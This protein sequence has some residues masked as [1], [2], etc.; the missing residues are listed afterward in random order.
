MFMNNGTITFITNNVIS[1]LT[2]K[3]GQISNMRELKNHIENYIQKNY[4]KKKDQAN[5]VIVDIENIWKKSAPTSL[6]RQDSNNRETELSPIPEVSSYFTI[7]KSNHENK[8]I[9]VPMEIAEYNLSNFLDSYHLFKTFLEGETLEGISKNGK[10]FEQWKISFDDITS[11]AHAFGLPDKRYS[12]RMLFSYLAYLNRQGKYD[13]MRFFPTSKNNDVEKNKQEIESQIINFLSNEISTFSS[14]EEYQ[15]KVVTLLSSIENFLKENSD[16]LT[17]Q[18]AENMSNLAKFVMSTLKDFD[19][20]LDTSWI[21]QYTYIESEGF[22]HLCYSI[23]SKEK[24]KYIKDDLENSYDYNA[25]FSTLNGEKWEYFHHLSKELKDKIK[26]KKILERYDDFYEK[27]KGF[28]DEITSTSMKFKTWENEELKNSLFQN[29]EGLKEYMNSPENIAENIMDYEDLKTLCDELDKYH[30]FDYVS[31]KDASTYINNLIQY[32]ENIPYSLTPDQKKELKE[33]LKKYNDLLNGPIKNRSQDTIDDFIKNISSLEWLTSN[34]HQ[35]EDLIQ[36]YSKITELGTEEISLAMI[37][38]DIPQF[39]QNTKK[40]YEQMETTEEQ[41]NTI[42]G[43]LD[44]LEKLNNNTSEYHNYLERSFP[45]DL[46]AEMVAHHE[47]YFKKSED[48][49]SFIRQNSRAFPYSIQQKD[50]EKLKN[51]WDTQLEGYQHKTDKIDKKEKEEEEKQFLYKFLNDISENKS[52]EQTYRELFDDTKTRDFRKNV[53]K[54]INSFNSYLERKNVPDIVVF[55]MIP[56]IRKKIIERSQR[57]QNL[58]TKEQLDTTEDHLQEFDSF[59]KN[60]KN[61]M[62][63]LSKEIAK[64]DQKIN[65]KRLVDFSHGRAVREIAWL[66]VFAYC[67]QQKDFIDFLKLGNFKVR[68]KAK[69]DGKENPEFMEQTMIPNFAK[70]ATKS[71]MIPNFVTIFQRWDHL[72]ATCE[73]NKICIQLGDYNNTILVLDKLNTE[74]QRI[75]N[76]TIYTFNSLRLEGAPEGSI[77]LFVRK[78][79]NNSAEVKA[80][81]EYYDQIKQSIENQRLRSMQQ[82]DFAVHRIA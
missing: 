62:Q 34:I 45:N 33:Y 7:Q 2:S 35:A 25:L 81:E 32:I 16:F 9:S 63:S 74:E 17:Y 70:Q 73:G 4:N 36:L 75:D 23:I 71:Y 37:L 66:D 24:K 64:L 58:F 54:F 57:L 18:E 42:A 65:M 12:K 69:Y 76:N 39:I 82:Q 29:L 61:C 31:S 80:G 72:K 60:P 59:F 49:E 40:M 56:K 22:P 38:T 8:K 6:T 77:N 47:P 14:T 20:M 43:Y 13:K 26:T 67:L 21:R 3:Y 48:L 5:I 28:E 51:E 1:Y 11:N 30:I 27:L 55:Y 68:F 41:K 44:K 79:S 50:I 78:S 52:L 10:H 46:I 15:K 19:H 53:D